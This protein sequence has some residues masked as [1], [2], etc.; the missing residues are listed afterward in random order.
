MIPFVLSE[1]CFSLIEPPY[2]VVGFEISLQS[3]NMV[4]STMDFKNSSAL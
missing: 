1:N 2:L 3:I 4:L